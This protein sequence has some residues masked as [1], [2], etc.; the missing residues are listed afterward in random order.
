MSPK[1]Q[2]RS[3]LK[4]AGRIIPRAKLSG[5]ILMRPKLQKQ[6]ALKLVGRII[7][8][9]GGFNTPQFAAESV[10][11]ACFGVHTR[12]Y[13]AYLWL[14]YKNFDFMSMRYLS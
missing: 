8:Q 5:T 12:D 13:L 9:S 7:P 2:K 11:K 3:A 14:N 6:S 4:L 1:F 10:S